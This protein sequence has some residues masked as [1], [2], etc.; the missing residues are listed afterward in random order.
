MKF[1]KLPLTD[2]SYRMLYSRRIK[3]LTYNVWCEGPNYYSRL[4]Q[5]LSYIKSEDPDIITLQE[6]KY[7]SYDKI[8]ETLNSYNYYNYQLTDKVKYHRLYG[9]IILSK[10]PIFNS[11]YQPFHNSKNQRGYT[12]YEIRFFEKNFSILTTHLDNNLLVQND[13]VN[14]LNSMLKTLKDSKII[15][16]GDFNF[17]KE[18]KK[19][20][21]LDSDPNGTPTFVS[22]QYKSRPDR[23]YSKGFEIKARRVVKFGK[24]SDHKCLIAEL[25]L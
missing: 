3:V 20:E 25:S 19:F 16:T 1:T 12:Y 8:I 15:L 17:Y 2:E 18:T 6:V 7:G 11:W 21:L 24:L 22:K 9:E 4:T 13:Q 14:K 23:I 10:F 5:I